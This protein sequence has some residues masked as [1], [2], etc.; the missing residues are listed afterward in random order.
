MSE[1]LSQETED[2]LIT[3]L[4]GAA[5]QNGSYKDIMARAGRADAAA[6]VEEA[7]DRH[8]ARQRA[9]GRPGW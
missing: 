9:S 7:M 6:R 2:A 8:A 3:L 1:E 4:M 5:V